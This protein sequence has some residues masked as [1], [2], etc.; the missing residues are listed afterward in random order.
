MEDKH[1]KFSPAEITIYGFIV[2][3]ID[4]LCIFIDLTGIGLA[5]A[6]FVQ[7]ATNFCLAYFVFKP[8]G[9]KNAMKAGRQ[10]IKFAL[11][12]LPITPV[13]VTAFTTSI[14]FFIEVF[15][16]NN[17]KLHALQNAVLSPK[18]AKSSA[19]VP[20][21]NKARVGGTPNTTAKNKGGAPV[22]KTQTTETTPDQ[23]EIKPSAEHADSQENQI[24]TEL[25]SNPDEIARPNQQENV[26]EKTK[27]SHIPLPE[28]TPEEFTARFQAL[29]TNEY[30]ENSP[31]IQNLKPL[32]KNAYYGNFM[33]QALDDF[34]NSEQMRGEFIDTL[35]HLQENENI[36]QSPEKDEKSLKMIERMIQVSSKASATGEVAEKVEY[37]A[38]TNQGRKFLEKGRKR[39]AH[40][41]AH[42]MFGLPEKFVNTPQGLELLH[43]K[44]DNKSIFLF[45]G[46]ESVHDLLTSEEFH[47]KS[48]INFDPYIKSELIDRNTNNIYRSE[49]ISAADPVI[50]QKIEQG[51]IPNADEI[52]MTYSVPFYL[53]NAKEIKDLINNA[54]LSLNEDGNIRI[55][56]IMLQNTEA[57]GENFGTRK[58]ALLDSL[59]SLTDSKDYNVTVFDDTIKIHKIKKLKK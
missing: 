7:T 4:V 8:K 57:G 16:H 20:G 23:Q 58:Q 45:G 14:P 15:V 9:D 30:M 51:E 5:I 2:I 10:V 48:V 33:N 31:D 17:E 46:G 49:D 50:S 11:N 34:N 37:Y 41:Y 6:P 52:W 55:S 18:D 28:E 36:R 19:S 35:H 25:Q 22:P 39:D 53:D 54:V 43:E 56:P 44:V 1:T 29:L 24:D 13:F 32:V 27:E 40:S 38:N 47:P 21:G 42:M 3:G 26:A 12:W 59:R